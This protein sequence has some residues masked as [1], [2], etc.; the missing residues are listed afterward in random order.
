MLEKLLCFNGGTSASE[1]CNSL[2]I[3]TQNNSINGGAAQG[4]ISGFLNAGCGSLG[5]GMVTEAG[6]NNLI[7]FKGSAQE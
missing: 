2:A 6:T 5:Y 7:I 4:A 1:Y 3:I